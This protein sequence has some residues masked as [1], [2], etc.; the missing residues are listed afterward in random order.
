MI[1]IAISCSPGLLIADEP[2]TALDV[3]IQAQIME[4]MKRISEETGTAVLLIT[5]DLGIVAGVCRTVAIMYAGRIVERAESAGIF[6]RPR[7]PYTHGLLSSTPR[8]DKPA[9]Q[10]TPIGGLPPSLVDPPDQC[11]FVPRC[12]YAVK[13]CRQA[14]PHLEETNPEHYA[15]CYRSGENLW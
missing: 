10:L 13:R 8:I 14:N 4:L 12:P 2:T 11:P 5:H 3:T 6:T 7:H 9:K 15:A 1:A